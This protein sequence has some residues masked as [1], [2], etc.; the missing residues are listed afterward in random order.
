MEFYLIKYDKI[1]NEKF[2]NSWFQS[3]LILFIVNKMNKN[4]LF[5]VALLLMTVTC[6]KI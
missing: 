6:I 1:Q 3:F 4:L 5:G 2:I